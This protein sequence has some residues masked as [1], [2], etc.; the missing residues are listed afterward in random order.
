MDT[1]KLILQLDDAFDEDPSLIGVKAKSLATVLKKGYKTP[2]GFCLTTYAYDLFLEENN[3]KEKIFSEIH[4]KPLKKMCWEEIWDTS[5]RIRSLFL[6]GI[7]PETVTDLI[8]KNLN[9]EQ[10]LNISSSTSKEDIRATKF[11]GV[12]GNFLNIKTLKEIQKAIQVIWS[13]L[14]SDASL[15]YKKELSLNI[16][17]S[18]MAILIQKADKKNCSG[19]AFSEAPHAEKKGHCFIEATPGESGNDTTPEKFFVN[20]EDSTVIESSS[21]LLNNNDLINILEVSKSLESHFGPIHIEWSGKNEDFHI[22]QVST[23]TSDQFFQSN[24][25]KFCFLKL[26]PQKEQLKNLAKKAESE[27][28]PLLNKNGEDLSNEDLKGL[29]PKELVKSLEKRFKESKKWQEIYQKQLLPLDHGVR[30]LGQLYNDSVLP[31]DPFEF[32]GLLQFDDLIPVK[33]TKSIKELASFLKKW[34]SLKNILE[35]NPNETLTANITSH[36]GGKDFLQSFFEIQ[37]KYFDIAFDFSNLIERN[38]LLTKHI[39]EL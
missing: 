2:A 1:N 30:R 27:L 7:F 23:L 31:K 9:F 12:Y 33:K 11:E 15:L 6:H 36:E 26:R 28:I 8:Q 25:Q 16:E 34:P 24:E 3:L 37:K 20:K 39:I 29:A 22:L 21:D 4:R 35:E 38:D 5:L 14:W 13:S 19:L 10:G 17:N 32:T 18:K